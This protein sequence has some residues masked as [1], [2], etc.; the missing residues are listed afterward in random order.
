MSLQRA[1]GILTAVP[2]FDFAHSLDFFSSFPVTHREQ[3]VADGALTRATQ[4]EGQVIVF[5]VR[6]AGKAP[7]PALEY[8]FFSDQPI[9]AE[10]KAAAVDRIA[11][12]LSLGDDLKPFYAIG[13]R[14]PQFAPIIQRLYGYHQVK[15]LT[16][17]ENAVWAILSQRNTLTLVREDEKRDNRTLWRQAGSERRRL[18]VLPRSRAAGQR[19]RPGRCHRARAKG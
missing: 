5:Q 9:R 14:D 2:P 11:F 18:P 17:F 8:S 12:F 7:G 16:P 10:T 3:I 6:A 13:Q 19:A 4:L 1:Q 15:F